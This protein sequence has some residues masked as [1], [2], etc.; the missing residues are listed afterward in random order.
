MRQD[1]R[2]GAAG[3]LSEGFVED[4]G[5]LCLG[6]I[7][8][9][10]ASRRRIETKRLSALL[11]KR[12]LDAECRGQTGEQRAEVLGEPGAGRDDRRGERVGQLERAIDRVR[13]RE[14][15]FG[16]RDPFT[17]AEALPITARSASWS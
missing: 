12:D 13:G 14:L 4:R 16:K 11:R 8:G 17:R 6:E 9:A 15:K 2:V 1:R 10:G 5:D 7:G 3:P